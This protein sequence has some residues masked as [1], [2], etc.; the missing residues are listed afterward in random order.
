MKSKLYTTKINKGDIKYIKK[1]QYIYIALILLWLLSAKIVSFSPLAIIRGMDDMLDLVFR[2]M[3]PNL[4]YFRVIMPEILQ[5]LEMA[6]ISSL[7]GVSLGVIFSLFIAENI[8]PSKLL[9]KVL[10][11]IFSILRT[12]PSL[13]WAAILVSIFSVGKFPGIIALTITAFLISVKL[14]R[15]NIETINKNIL[16]NI[17]STGGNK[18]QILR[19]GVIPSLTDIGISV[20]FIVLEINIR[21][22][23]VLGL[24]GAGGIGQILYRDLNHFRYDNVSSI[25]ISLFLVILFIDYISLFARKKLKKSNIDL[26]LINKFKNKNKLKLY[27]YIQMIKIPIILIL[28]IVLLNALVKTIGIDFERFL[29][30]LDTGKTIILRMINIDLTYTSNM[31]VGIK[32]SFFIAIFG[33]INGALIAIILSYF[34]A[35]NIA[36][37]KSISFLGK[38]VSNILRTFPPIIMAIIFLRGV[39]N[40]PIAGAM[41]LSIYSAGVLT[42]LYS[43]VLESTDSNIKNSILV[44]GSSNLNIYKHG[45]IPHTFSNFISLVLY[46]LES[47][48]RNATILGMV[49]AGGVGSLL[50]RNINWRNWERV[51]LLILGISVMIIIIDLISYKIRKKYI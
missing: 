30:G 28:I 31:L 29:M 43:E 16:D 1:K 7:L 10:N 22:A 33:T 49:G 18:F 47:N 51:G 19:Y 12:I 13:V 42:K 36:P 40:G 44:T 2:L 20:Y 4:S 11:I 15:E 25:I 48:I 9:A 46:R 21:S 39:G 26:F 23:T 35:S 24:V 5:T 14:L 45:L 6:I 34:T 17:N 41:A 3:S 37:L 27:K 50:N 32:E 38:A 8:A